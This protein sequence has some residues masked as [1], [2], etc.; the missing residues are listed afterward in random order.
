[1]ECHSE[2][3][4]GGDGSGLPAERSQDTCVSVCACV[5]VCAL[6]PLSKGPLLSSCHLSNRASPSP[7]QPLVDF[8]SLSAGSDSMWPFVSGCFHAA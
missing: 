1:M 3:L 4:A 7:W 6:S 8:L 5:P 2:G